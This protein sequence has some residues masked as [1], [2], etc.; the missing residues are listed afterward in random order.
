MA[1]KANYDKFP[2]VAAGASNECAVGWDAIGLQLAGA[3]CGMRVECYPGAQVEDLQSELAQRLRPD[4]VICASDAYKDVA[5]IRAMLA[6]HLGDD[7]VF[8]R[9]NGLMLEDWF[10]LREHCN[11]C[12]KRSA[13]PS[14]GNRACDWHGCCRCWR[15]KCDVL[16]YAD[17]ARWEI[18]LRYRR[19]DMGNIGCDNKEASFAEKYKCGF[20]VGMARGGPS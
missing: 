10:G 7:R 19:F 3:S 1:R 5:E 18:Q 11:G 14:T 9:M 12:A 13:P 4:T 17:M 15:R 20:F 6:T 16:V 2:F 8:G